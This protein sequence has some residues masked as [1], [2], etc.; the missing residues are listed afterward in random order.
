VFTEVLLSLQR[1]RLCWCE[2]GQG[3]PMYHSHSKACQRV[4]DLFSGS[5]TKTE[6]KPNKTG[7]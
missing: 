6:E 1:A 2:Y 3:N 7:A 4:R 5:P